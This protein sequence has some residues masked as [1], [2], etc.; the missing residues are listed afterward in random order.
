[1]NATPKPAFD[2]LE[3]PAQREYRL[4]GDPEGIGPLVDQI[5]AFIAEATGT[6]DGSEQFIG[7]ALQEA[8][9]NAVIHGCGNDP[10]KSVHCLV[11][12][13]PGET[14]IV[15]RD[16]GPGFDYRL[17]GSPLT[18]EGLASDHGRGVHMMLQIMDEIHYE[19]HGTEL[20]MRK[21]LGSF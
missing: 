21:K 16:P 9:A 18:R 13:R 10:A 19:N 6:T 12:C 4:R 3:F 15:V 2:I 1:M 7:L 14:A 8:L 20:H 5:T 11:G 17:L